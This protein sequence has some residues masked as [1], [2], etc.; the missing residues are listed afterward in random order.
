[1]TSGFYKQDS[2]SGEWFF[3]PNAVWFPDGSKLEAPKKDEYSYPIH[4]WFWSD[5]YPE[6]Y[7]I[8]NEEDQE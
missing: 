5:D 1:M 6:G 4:G 7:P 3:A 2:E 8:P